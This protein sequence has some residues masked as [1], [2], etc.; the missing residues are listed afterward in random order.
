MLHTAK[1]GPSQ[2]EVAGIPGS[3]EMLGSFAVWFAYVTGHLPMLDRALVRSHQPNTLW[4]TWPEVVENL[5]ALVELG[6][7]A[8]RQFI[9]VVTQEHR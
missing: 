8:L 5:R 1:H 7:D 4:L 3:G 2:K 6:G 9:L